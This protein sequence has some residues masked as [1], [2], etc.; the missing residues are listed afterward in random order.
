MHR[1][2]HFVQCLTRRLARFLRALATMPRTSS[3]FSSNSCA[4]LRIAVISSTIFAMTG[5]L[6]SRQPMPAERHPSCTHCFVG[7]SE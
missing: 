5:C 4:R 6:Q 7:S 2:T 3:G 1:A